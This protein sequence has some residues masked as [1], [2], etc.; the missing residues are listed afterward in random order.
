[1]RQLLDSAPALVFLAGVFLKDIYTATLWLMISLVLLVD[2]GDLKATAAV[3]DV[4]NSIKLAEAMVR[5]RGRKQK[6]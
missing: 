2:A 5:V 1:M 4:H 6:K 3:S